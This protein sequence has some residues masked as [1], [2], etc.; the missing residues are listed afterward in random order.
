MSQ[1]PSNFD[2]LVYGPIFCDMI[3]TDL[4]A[5]PAL[6]KEIFA[7]NFAMA[8][9]GSAIV[10]AGLRRLGA[11]VGLIADLGNDS[12]SKLMA[13]MLDDLKLDR[14]LTRRHAEA[15]HQLTVALS[16]PRDRAFITRFRR[17]STPPDLETILKQSGAQHLHICSFWAVLETPRICVL[18]HDAGMTVSFDPGWD[19]EALRS[20]TVQDII[21]E[22]DFFL[23]NE[24]ELLYLAESRSVADA[25]HDISRRMSRGQLILKQGSRGAVAYTRAGETAVRVPPIPIAPVD[26][27]GAGD[28]FDAGFLYGLINGQSLTT[29]MEMGAVCGGLATT[30]ISGSLGCPTL[31]EVEAWRLK[32]QS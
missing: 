16:F 18:A 6:G 17:P 15:L 25:A 4:P 10:A 23:P 22:L 14:S 5:M 30:R 7:D 28:S 8:L 12:L 13:A 20:K 27:T 29:S 31:Q 21:P 3:F 24:M 9:G 19:E 32:L 26:T 11:K 1:S 2:I